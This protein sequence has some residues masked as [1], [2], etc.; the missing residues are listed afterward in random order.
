MT[1]TIKTA[2][3]NN[4]VAVQLDAEQLL[5]DAA[6]VL[7]MARKVKTELLAERPETARVAASRIPE[8]SAGLGV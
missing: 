1:T 6:F 3:I 5:R 8:M 4:S 7:R 2:Q